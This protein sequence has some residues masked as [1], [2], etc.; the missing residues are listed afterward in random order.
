MFFSMNCRKQKAG[1]RRAALRLAFR[2][3]LE[4]WNALLSVR[5]ITCKEPR[6]SFVESSQISW[7]VFFIHGKT[8]VFGWVIITVPFSIACTGW[9]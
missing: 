6:Q 5:E 8:M 4:S 3:S 1:K 7:Y 9:L 2:M